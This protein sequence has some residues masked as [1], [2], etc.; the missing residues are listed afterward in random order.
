MGVNT[1]TG[2]TH[3]SDMQMGFEYYSKECLEEGC[4]SLHT[5]LVEWRAK[6]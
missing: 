3:W 2:D 4:S 1:D 6:G 5:G